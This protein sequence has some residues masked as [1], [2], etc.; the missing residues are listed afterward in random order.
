[1][2]PPQNCGP[3]AVE[4]SGE[5]LALSGSLPWEHCAPRGRASCAERPVCRAKRD[6]RACRELLG[7][8]GHRALTPPSPSAVPKGMRMPAVTF[9][10][11]LTLTLRRNG[12]M[13]LLGGEAKMEF[14]Q[15]NGTLWKLPGLC[16]FLH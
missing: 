10:C 11:V 8:S 9:T 1:M 12:K 6:A 3:E 2:E 16:L 15:V 4:S 5:G 13:R 7:G 14:M